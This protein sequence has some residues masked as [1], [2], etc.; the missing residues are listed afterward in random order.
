METQEA[1]ATEIVVRG[2]YE[3]RG[4]VLVCRAKKYGHRFL[5]GGH[6]EFAE[7]AKEALAR[8][9]LEEMGL[10]CRVGELLGVSEQTYLSRSGKETHEFSLVFRVSCPGARLA[11]PPAG[12]EGH[13]A[14]EWLAADALMKENVLPLAQTKALARWLAKGP[15]YVGD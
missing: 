8:E 15:G 9:W 1:N 5:P 11:S 6:V 7:G 13:I 12:V 4:K 3:K 10:A 2:W 14:F